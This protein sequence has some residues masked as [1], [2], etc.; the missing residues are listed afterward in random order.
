MSRQCVVRAFIGQWKLRFGGLTFGTVSRMP[1]E[2]PDKLWHLCLW[3]SFLL[4]HTQVALWWLKPS[5]P[6]SQWRNLDQLLAP[7]CP[8][9]ALIFEGV[10]PANIFSLPSLLSSFLPSFLSP[11]FL[12]FSPLFHFSAFYIKQK[13][14][15]T[16]KENTSWNEKL[17]VETMNSNQTSSIFPF[18][19]VIAASGR[20]SMAYW[21]KFLKISDSPQWKWLV[22]SGQCREPESRSIQLNIR[23]G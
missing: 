9:A 10:W 6:S 5:G 12:F 3:L 23:R 8:G 19:D 18:P 15:N 13:E 16:L 22:F 21:C 14:I 20:K 2:M 4:L 11:P 7:L 17:R 1:L